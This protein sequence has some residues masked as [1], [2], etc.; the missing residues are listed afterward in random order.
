[1]GLNFKLYELQLK[2]VGNLCITV[3]GT[4]YSVN[5][6]ASFIN[7]SL[8]FLFIYGTVGPCRDLPYLLSL[9]TKI[10]S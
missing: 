8:N 4:H 5:Q 2:K 6:M 7:D 1:M 3:K 10:R 9:Q